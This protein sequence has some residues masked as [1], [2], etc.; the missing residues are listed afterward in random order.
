MDILGS[1][2]KSRG[3][4]LILKLS[5]IDK[6][7]RYFIFGN[8]KNYKNIRIKNY[9]HNLY[10]MIICHIKLFQKI[11]QKMDV[12]LM[13]YQNK[14]TAAGNVGNIIDFTSPLKLFDYIA[15]GKII[16][17]SNVKVLKEILIDKKNVIL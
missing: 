6:E 4:D 16:I 12:L 13:P 7:N 5:K 17:S 3:V 11:S 10:L 1:C 8:L 2:Y 9:N 14:I 15:C